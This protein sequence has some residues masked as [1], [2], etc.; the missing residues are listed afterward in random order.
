MN[1]GGASLVSKKKYNEKLPIIT[2]ITVVYNACKTIERTIKSVI[3][4]EYVNI[5]YIIVDGGSTDGTVD[6]I[7]KYQNNID[8]WISEPDKGIYYAMNKGIEFSNG[9]YICLLNADDWYEKD[10]CKV[11]AQRI[12]K[13]NSEYGVYYG[14]ARVINLNGE[15]VDIQGTTVHIINRASIAHQ[16]CFIS[17]D[18]YSR[19]TYDTMYKSAA[20][21]DMMC[22][23]IKNDVK[24]NF[25]ENILVNYSLNGMSDSVLGQQETYRIRKKYGYIS[26]INYIIHEISLKLATIKRKKR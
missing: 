10:T 16:T 8:Y 15:T 19:Y 9:D 5:E 23:L 7:K 4:Q 11:V 14:M 17:K 12:I 2:V 1:C 24:F 13:T 3:A 18:V 6:I 20:D 26:Q 21:Y 22:K 25:I